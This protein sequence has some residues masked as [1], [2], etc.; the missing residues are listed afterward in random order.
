VI[1]TIV[2][3][4]ILLAFLYSQLGGQNCLFEPSGPFT[5]EVSIAM[6]K[7]FGASYVICGHSERKLMF[8]D[9]DDVINMKL[10]QV[11]AEG[12]RPILCIGENEDQNDEGINREVN[13]TALFLLRPT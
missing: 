5:G 8:G 11:L 3:R 4:V 2:T 10:K 1:Y 6:V 13:V 12:L 7:D 9:E